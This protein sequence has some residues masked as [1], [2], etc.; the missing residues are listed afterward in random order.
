[1]ATKPPPGKATSDK[2]SSLASEVLRG[3]KP[4]AAEAKS[5]AG[6]ALSQD[7]RKG[8]NKPKKR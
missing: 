7:A 3:K 8:P 2:V 6:S 5:L 1:M 4:T